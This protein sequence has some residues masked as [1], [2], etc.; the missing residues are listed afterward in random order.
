MSQ[1]MSVQPAGQLPPPKTPGILA[2]AII[3]AVMIIGALLLNGRAIEQYL[4][5]YGDIY[6]FLLYH[7]KWPIE[8]VQGVALLIWGSYTVVFTVLSYSAIGRVLVGRPTLRVATIGLLALVAQAPLLFLEA[9]LH[10][11]PS[12][13]T[14]LRDLQCFD[15]RTKGRV[16]VWYYRD[17]D[18]AITLFENGYGG[19]WRGQELQP[20]TQ[21]ICD[22]AQAKWKASDSEAQL[23]EAARRAAAAEMEKKF[24]AL[25]TT[26]NFADNTRVTMH[27]KSV[28][29]VFSQEFDLGI[30]LI[31]LRTIHQSET[32]KGNSELV[33]NVCNNGEWKI[34][35]QDLHIWYVPDD[36]SRTVRWQ[37]SLKDFPNGGCNRYSAL[38]EIDDISSLTS[39]KGTLYFSDTSAK[40]LISTY[41]ADK[42]AERPANV[43]G[44]PPI[45]PS[46]S[47]PAKQP[48]MP[49]P[50][51][52][53]FFQEP[54][55]YPYELMP[56]TS[57]LDDPTEI[58]ISYGRTITLGAN[59]TYL[60]GR[61]PEHWG[62]KAMDG[63]IAITRR[64]NQ[65]LYVASGKWAELYDFETVD[66]VT[67]P[68]RFYTFRSASP[69][70]ST[71]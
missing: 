15:T 67:C 68:A 45:G 21:H 4:F 62:I 23:R 65:K 71:Q 13:I 18:G 57:P 38:A 1:P 49:D 33:L 3:G 54:I 35:D 52:P 60:A 26:H 30:K 51:T 20:A 59:E 70:G 6:R 25:E 41:I 11:S 39:L 64:S 14:D 44:V 47:I 9:A 29:L 12:P 2:A 16:T 50:L 43:A 53:S 58:E 66:C 36:Q 69:N 55:T 63:M 61:T 48:S 17:Q 46:A 31:T 19:T 28:F 5:G 7:T 27:W 34:V 56:V 22:A 10:K 24:A 8:A 42:P 37:Y 32:K 40:H